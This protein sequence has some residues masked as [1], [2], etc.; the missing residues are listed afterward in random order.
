[1]PAANRTYFCDANN[2]NCYSL[3]RLGSSDFT[4]AKEYCEVLG[5]GLPEFSFNLI[6]G[7]P[8]SGK[9]TWARRHVAAHPAR[10]Y[11]VLGASLVLEQMRVGRGGGRGVAAVLAGARVVTGAS[12]S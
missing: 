4:V 1:M 10:R 2:N 12:Y 11:C 5:G 7:Q 8:G 9:T 6:A 3:V